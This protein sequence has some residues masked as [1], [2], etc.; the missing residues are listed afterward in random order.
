M[1]KFV[2][3]VPFQPNLVPV[4]YT[5]TDS[6]SPL[7]YDQPHD[8][9][10]LNAVNA[11]AAEGESIEMIILLP[12]CPE[13]NNCM[14]NMPLIRSQI[15]TLT[16]AKHLD[17]TIN[18]LT[19]DDSEE[20]EV[21]LRLYGDLLSHL[22][23]NDEVYFCVTY[24]TKPVPLVQMMALRYA[25]H[26]RSNL[27]VGA[28]VYGKLH[29]SVRNPEGGDLFDVTSLFYMEELSESFWRMGISDPEEKMKAFM[30]SEREGKEDDPSE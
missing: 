4:V 21:M 25:F 1:K 22:N 5:P 26:A 9:P 15:Q 10:I 8:F 20:I 13:G 11:Y 17:C 12:V 3:S 14:K 18:V 2:A 7:V 30:L 6:T 24:G 29:G 16:E 19:Y 23:D 27:F 28:I